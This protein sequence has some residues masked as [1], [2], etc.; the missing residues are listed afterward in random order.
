MN[1]D[2]T[3]HYLVL[4]VSDATAVV[5]FSTG[6]VILPVRSTAVERTIHVTKLQSEDLLS[7][8]RWYFVSQMAWVPESSKERTSLK[9]VL[10]V[11]IRRSEYI[12]AR[13]ALPVCC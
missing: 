3:R 7:S 13:S 2:F 1:N 11:L 4:Q 6:F 9:I 5:A 12:T 10:V 8:P